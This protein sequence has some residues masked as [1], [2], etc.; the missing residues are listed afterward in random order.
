MNTSATRHFQFTLLFVLAQNRSVVQVGD[1]YDSHNSLQHL[2]RDF[3][4]GQGHKHADFPNFPVVLANCTP[5]MQDETGDMEGI[6]MI[7]QRG[8]TL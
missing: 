4:D 7:N 3:I 1:S 8:K 5:C 6:G 2:A